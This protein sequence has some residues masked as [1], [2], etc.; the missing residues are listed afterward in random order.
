[1]PFATC[2]LTE[3]YN[4]LIEYSDLICPLQVKAQAS[5]NRQDV[6]KA[7]RSAIR[8]GFGGG[9]DKGAEHV[10]EGEAVEYRSYS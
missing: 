8:R 3:E 5:P 6:P 1:M 9:E 10:R 4:S 2:L 7:A